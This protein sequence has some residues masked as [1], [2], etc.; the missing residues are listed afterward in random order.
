MTPT[1]FRL[2]RCSQGCEIMAQTTAQATFVVAQTV[3]VTWSGITSN[4]PKVFAGTVV[5][6]GGPAPAISFANVSN[7]G[8]TVNAS[9]AFSGTVNLLVLD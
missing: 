9:D 4:P 8:C 7:T 3:A 2:N 1:H 5:T 6:D